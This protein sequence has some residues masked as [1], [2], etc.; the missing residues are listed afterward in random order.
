VL[1]LAVN[2]AVQTV[3]LVCCRL[4]RVPPVAVVSER[5][6]AGGAALKVNVTVA[7]L[8]L[9]V[10]LVLLRLIATVGAVVSTIKLSAVLGAL[11]L[12]AASVAVTV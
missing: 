9:A 8:L 11:V 10:R 4:V 3:G 12:P 2:N 1:P 5:L 6:N 7:V